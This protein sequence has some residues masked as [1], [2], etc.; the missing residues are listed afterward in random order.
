MKVGNIVNECKS[1]RNVIN[2]KESDDASVRDSRTVDEENEEESKMD[3]KEESSGGD[4]IESEKEAS[5]YCMLSPVIVS[6][7]YASLCY[8]LLCHV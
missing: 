5:R 2:D 8:S 6:Y 7:L 3:D 1:K 4:E